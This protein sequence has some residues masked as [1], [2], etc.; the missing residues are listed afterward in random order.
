MI[1]SRMPGFNR[2]LA[3]VLLTLIA[4]HAS[5]EDK[6]VRH[7]QGRELYNYRC[8]YC[9]GYSGDAK[10]LAASYMQPAPRDFT[11]TP[12]AA[13]GRQRMI[14]VVTHG[15]PQTAMKGFSYYLNADEVELVVDFVRAEF[16]EAQ[17]I[18]TRYHTPE[19]G[20]PNH[21]AYAVAFPFA[22]GQLALDTPQETLSLEQRKG[23]RLF[24]TSCVSCHDRARVEDEGAIWELRAISY[25]RN[26]FSFT[27]FDATTSASVY[28]EHDQVPEISDLTPLEKQ[29][30]Q[31]FQANCA[32]CHAA[33]GT[34]KNWI[35]SFLDVKPRNLTDSVAMGSM[36]SERLRHVIREGLEGTSM[37]AWKAVLSTEQIDALISYVSKAFYPLSDHAARAN[38]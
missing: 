16:M 11:Q 19:N 32:F 28:A 3:A 29:G 1:V 35:G 30:E 38:P 27:E 24:L 22:T 26:N 21:D 37:P 15:I 12:L 2:W 7:E 18:N 6:A 5:G 20:W 10:T 17:R 4:V 9:H 34:G 23:L 31:L 8:Y 36:N 25:P 13:L 33:D 14:D